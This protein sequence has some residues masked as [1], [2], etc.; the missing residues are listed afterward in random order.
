MVE[1]TEEMK[2]TTIDFYDQF[3]PIYE[4][5]PFKIVT[6]ATE[7]FARTVFSTALTETRQPVV[8][9]LGCGGGRDALSLQSMYFS[10]VCVD[11]SLVM[12]QTA[13]EK[14]LP[15]VLMDQEQLG[16]KPESFDGVW[17]RVSLLHSPP[18]VLPEILADLRLILKP[19]G[20]LF[21]AMKASIGQFVETEFK[22]TENGSIYYCYWPPYR[23]HGL[24]ET[25]GF[26]VGELSIH[27]KDAFG[28]RY[29]FE[30]FAVKE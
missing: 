4:R 18:Q 27:G 22:T 20:V 6:N 19:K 12:C 7:K 16:F 1:R 24:L 13:R 11:L 25:L 10:L 3:A 23:L 5:R 26:E 29:Y 9:D 30:I 17:S 2:K 15:T 28:E 14:R 8:L 21:L